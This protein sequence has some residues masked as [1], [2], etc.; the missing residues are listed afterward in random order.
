MNPDF[1]LINSGEY[2]NLIRHLIAF[3]ILRESAKKYGYG[4]PTDVWEAVLTAL[5]YEPGK[6]KTPDPPAT[7]TG[8]IVEATA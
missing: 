3:D 8:E 7:A 2:A 4:P 6:P 1:M 5:G